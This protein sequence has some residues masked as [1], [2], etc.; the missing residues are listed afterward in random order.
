MIAPF[1]QIQLN[2]R[3]M[4]AALS[5][6]LLLPA[7]SACGS[8]FETFE[9]KAD[10][11]L[12]I[13]NWADYLHPDAIPEF[14]RRYSCKVVYDTFASNEALLAKLQAG[15][16]LYDVIVPSSYMV[17]QL[18]K[19]DILSLLDHDRL[20][21]LAHMMPRFTNSA[22]DPGLKHCV[23]Y[24]WGTTGIGFSLAKMSE[25]GLIK[26][27]S[28][29][30]LP[31]EVFWDKRLSQRMTLLDDGREVIGMALKMAGHSYNTVE[32]AIIASATN[33]LIE[34]KPLTMCYTSDQVIVELASG[35]S[36]LSQ[37]FSGD[38]YQA[39]RDNPDLRYVI[40][41]NGASIWTDNFCIPKTAPHVDLAYKWINYMLE[42]AV[43]AA[44]AN[45]T[46]YAIAN[47][48]AWKLVD[49]HLRQ[50]PNLY[51]PPRVMERCE[52]LGEIGSA[53]FIF[54]SM[55]TELKC[56]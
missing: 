15:G 7:L 55:W 40:P 12:N 33:K 27:S 47:E 19:L 51:P 52:E 29:L 1:E 6:M 53:I 24:T 43:A 36:Y 35:D 56:A 37:V 22:F 39:R 3:Q 31:W 10:H 38:A 14:E 42:P 54:D 16:S 44:C 20:P 34:Q 23:P 26:D 41:S 9:Q 49:S 48:T 50:D 18:H 46:N 5:S 17:K 8:R 25:L 4:L 2:R 45:F 28:N 30:S 13:L 32:K 21:G 11:Q